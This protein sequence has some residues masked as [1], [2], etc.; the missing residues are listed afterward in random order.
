MK[1]DRLSTEDIR[2]MFEEAFLNQVGVENNIDSFDVEAERGTD[3]TITVNVTVSG[4]A[5]S[6]TIDDFRNGKVKNADTVKIERYDV[7][8][9]TLKLVPSLT[10]FLNGMDYLIVYKSV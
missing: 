10:A 1:T 7:G 9:M 4:M 2:D 3:N 5:G 8:E 6:V